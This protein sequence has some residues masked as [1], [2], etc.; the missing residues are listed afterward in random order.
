MAQIRLPLEDFLKNFPFSENRPKQTD[1]LRKICDAYN[2]GGR[3][4]K[5]GNRTPNGEIQ[6]S[7]SNQTK[8]KRPGDMLFQYQ[9]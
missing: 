2:N 6:I 8:K 3:C 1:A 9:D 5:E 4:V 7:N